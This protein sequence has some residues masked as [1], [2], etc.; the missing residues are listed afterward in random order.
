MLL[1]SLPMLETMHQQIINS[2]QTVPL[3]A[4]PIRHSNELLDRVVVC[5]LGK[6]GYRVVQQLYHLTPRPQITVVHLDDGKTS[7]S[8]QIS[9]L[10]GVKTIIGDARDM[11]IL[12]QAEVQR[13]TTIAAVTSDDLVNLQIGLSA[14]RAHPHLHLVLRVFSDTLAEK[15]SDLF[16]ISTTYSTSELA[17]STLSAAA[18]L[19]GVSQAFFVDDDLLATDQRTTRANDGL[20][21]KSIQA[22]RAQEQ[23]L[24]IALRR[25][26]KMISLPPLETTIAPGDELTVL[27]TLDTLARLRE[28]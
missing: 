5:G 28:R 22:I 12:Q 24:V 20:N 14:R 25:Q 16:H 1:G 17:G 9:D 2:T 7:F 19:S 27:A 4:R 18:I 10:V 23:A 6:V 26:G 13:A 8:R 21:G 11:A 3:S 15:L